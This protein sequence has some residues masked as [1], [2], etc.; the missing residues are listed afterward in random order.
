MHIS[1]LILLVKVLYMKYRSICEN[2]FAQQPVSVAHSAVTNRKVDGSSPPVG[3]MCRQTR[4]AVNILK[5]SYFLD[6]VDFSAGSLFGSV[7][8]LCGFCEVGVFGDA[9]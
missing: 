9:A 2:R 6:G 1:V 8:V 5:C 7:V 3:K 4:F